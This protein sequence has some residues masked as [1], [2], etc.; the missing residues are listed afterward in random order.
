MISWLFMAPERSQHLAKFFA[1]GVFR[2]QVAF[3]K[4]AE[5]ASFRASRSVADQFGDAVELRFEAGLQ[6][7]I[8]H[9]LDEFFEID[10][11]S[12]FTVYFRRITFM[13]VLGALTA[14]LRNNLS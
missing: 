1:Y 2:E 8:A 7:E 6:E 5:M 13:K 4:R 10:R 3:L 11:I 9:A 14:L 12:R